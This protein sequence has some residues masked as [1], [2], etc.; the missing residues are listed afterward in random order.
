MA[1]EVAPGNPDYVA[2]NTRDEIRRRYTRFSRQAPIIILT[3]PK[4]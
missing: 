1:R 2:G 3:Q 4:D